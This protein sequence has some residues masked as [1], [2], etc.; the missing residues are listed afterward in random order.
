MS[1]TPAEQF[2]ALPPYTYVPGVVPHPISH[3][4]GH[5]HDAG[6]L[7]ENWPDEKVLQWGV[8]LFNSGF[9]WES[10]EVWEHLWLKFGRVTDEAGTVKGLIKLAACG[11]KCL[12]SN[13][14]GAVRHASRAEELLNASVASELFASIDLNRAQ[15]LAATARTAPPIPTMP[16]DG[17]PTVLD[18]FC[19]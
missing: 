14:N 5:M 19:L 10:H 17:T 9:Y 18:G 4:D 13:L 16:S 7:P 8:R 2:P 15:H 3:P 6:E 11:V 1:A 12:E